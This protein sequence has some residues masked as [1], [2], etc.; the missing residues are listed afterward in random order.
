MRGLTDRDAQTKNLPL[1]RDCLKYLSMTPKAPADIDNWVMDPPAANA[2]DSILTAR[3]IE[4]SLVPQLNESLPITPLKVEQLPSR[5]VLYLVCFISISST[6]AMFYIL[7]YGF[8]GLWGILSWL[9][10]HSRLLF[11]TEIFKKMREGLEP[12]IGMGTSRLIKLTLIVWLLLNIYA[13]VILWNSQYLLESW[14]ATS[15]FLETCK[16]QQVWSAREH[17]WRI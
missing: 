17:K 15:D 10:N 8:N 9:D 14:S 3:T 11:R 4:S 5:S 16:M 2:S 6:L 13:G 12:Q 1:G 7:Q